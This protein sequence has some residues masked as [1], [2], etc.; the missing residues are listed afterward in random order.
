MGIFNERAKKEIHEF[1]KLN[2][3]QME[4]IGGKCRYNFRCHMNAVHDAI[5]NDEKRL[6][7]CMYI[8]GDHPIIHFVNIDKDGT[9]IDNTL[10]HWSSAHKYYFVRDVKEKEFFDVNSTL[11]TFRYELRNKLTFFTKLFSDIEN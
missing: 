7:L 8:H 4:V 10:G 6:A 11:S 1:V 3:K 2:Y 9:Y 5:D